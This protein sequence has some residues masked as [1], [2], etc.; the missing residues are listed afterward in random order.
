MNDLYIFQLP[1]GSK[2]LI[3]GMILL[4]HRI[5][6]RNRHQFINNFISKNDARVI[7]CKFDFLNTHL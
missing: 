1:T 2:L 5:Y 6:L 4:V 3:D 7:S